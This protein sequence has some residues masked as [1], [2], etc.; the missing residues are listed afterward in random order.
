MHET[1]PL[2]I[3]RK[4]RSILMAA[5]IVEAV[6]Y[7]VSLTDSIVAGN[8]LGGTAFA[9]IGLIAPFLSVSVFIS[10]VISSGMVLNYS[11][12]VGAFEKRRALEFFSQGVYTAVISGAVYAALLLLIREPVLARISASPEMLRCAREYYDVILMYIMVNPLAYLLDNMLVADGSEKL[13]A[14]ANI[15]AILLNVFLSIVFAYWW[16]VRGIAAA[17][18]ASNITYIIIACLHF[19]SRRNTLRLVRHWTRADF[20]LIIRSGAVNAST[21]AFEALTIFALNLFAVNYFDSGTLILLVMLE[22]FLGLLTLFTGLSM[23]AQPLIGTLRGERNSKALRSLMRTVSSD[24]A[25]AGFIFTV[26]TFSFAPYLV[27]AFGISGALL[28]GG[29]TALRIVSVTLVPHAL[30]ILFFIYYHLIGRQ[31]LAF[32]ICAYKNLISPLALVLLFSVLLKS[33]LGIWIGLA[34]APLLSLL[35]C[36]QGIFLKLRGA[37]FPFLLPVENNDRTFIYAFDI[38]PE[39]AAAMSR[40]AGEVLSAFPVS[41]RTR[42]IAGLFIEDML[43]LIQDKNAGRKLR[44]ECTVMAEPDGV[45]IIL[46]DSGVIFDITDGDA[47]PDSFRQYVVA[48]LMTANRRKIYLTTT[49]YNRNELFFAEN[50]A[51]PKA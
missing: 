10:S 41:E 20:R 9:A 6:N 27:R 18:A 19:T 49:G 3:I 50:E 43:M 11:Y 24:M 34:A 46:R 5:I 35:L 37:D 1:K 17:S 22:K 29:A 25:A 51:A 26:L 33:D 45:R 36:S 44:A 30:L 47:L 12:H 15:L 42:A 21:Y 16:G 13:S 4:Y 48:S 40:T 2:F 8:I 23:A 38:S 14:A 39:N 31:L 32:T 7:I 28:E